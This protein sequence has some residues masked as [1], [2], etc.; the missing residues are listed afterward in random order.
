MIS[1]VALLVALLV[2]G[3]QDAPVVE[4]NNNIPANAGDSSFFL[5]PQALPL[6]QEPQGNFSIYFPTPP[7]QA[8]RQSEVDIGQL[9]MQQWVAEDASGQYYVVSYADYPAAVLKLGSGQQLLEGVEAQLLAKLH[10]KQTSRTVLSLENEQ[11]AIAFEAEA[12]RKHWHLNYQ[13]YLIDNRL[14]QL[15]IHSALGPI[16]TQDSLDFFGNFRVL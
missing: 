14:Y 12:K 1:I 9:K 5:S 6:F 2:F 10:A 11:Q 16:S 4:E 3:C 7:Q 8:T 15:G 13:L